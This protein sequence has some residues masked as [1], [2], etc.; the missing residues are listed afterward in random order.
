MK[1]VWTIS[2][3]LA[4]TYAAI[5]VAIYAQIAT[6]PQPVVRMTG[7]VPNAVEMY[8][9]GSTVLYKQPVGT[10]PRVP[11]QDSND[12]AQRYALFVCE[13]QTAYASTPSIQALLDKHKIKCQ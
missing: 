4:I 1:K 8:A 9:D 13:L 12:V 10:I 5:G 3:L 7:P 11:P 6:P 2:F